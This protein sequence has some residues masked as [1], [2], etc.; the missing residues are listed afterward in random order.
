MNRF[1]YI[2]F[3]CGKQ[4]R[5]KTNTFGPLQKP[6]RKFILCFGRIEACFQLPNKSKRKKIV[7]EGNMK[8]RF[9]LWIEPNI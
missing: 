7:I 3:L 2:S 4:L 6:K 8:M 1:Y 9:G 5:E